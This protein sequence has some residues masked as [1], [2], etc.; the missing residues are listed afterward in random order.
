LIY[1]AFVA[2]MALGQLGLTGFGA[3]F[4]WPQWA[5]WTSMTNPLSMGACCFFA[6]IFTRGFLSTASNF[7]RLDKSI[8]FVAVISVVIIFSA[9]FLSYRFTA[10]LTNTAIIICVISL[11]TAALYSLSQGHY[12]ARYFL[13][14]WT[15]LLLSVIVLALRNLGVLPSNI[16]TA[17]AVLIGSALEMLLLSFA[18]ADRINLVR[19]EKEAAQAQALATEQ[20][21]VEVLRQ[22]EH[23]LETRVTERTLALEAANTRLKENQQ[24]LNELAH[25][26]TLTGLANRLLFI[27]RL[28]LAIE[29]AKRSNSVFAL[30]MIDL[31]GFKEINDS[32]GHTTGDTVLIAVA[33][34]LSAVVRASDTVARFGGDEFVIIL[35]SLANINNITMIMDKFVT[36]MNDP[37]ALKSGEQV[38]IGISIGVAFYPQHGPDAERLI[39][40]ADKAMYESKKTGVSPVLA[41]V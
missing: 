22:S 4:L 36:A 21:M 8:I 3:Q 20:S 19:W 9:L 5:W 26:D 28:S 6:A 37:V 14:A 17:N 11:F 23:L 39:N 7:P 18:L 35:E 41:T 15:V 34:R 10:W 12:G 38:N 25:H 33:Q 40:Y 1:I 29:R 2:S 24:L 16:F 31:N 30:L 13:L 27:D 32:Y